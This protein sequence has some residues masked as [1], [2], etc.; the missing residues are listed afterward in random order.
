ML[1][2]VKFVY[3]DTFNFTFKA[4]LSTRPEKYMGELEQWN[5]A[6][7]YLEEALKK[8]GIDYTINPGDGAFYGPK[9]DFDVKDALG[10]SWQLATIQV[11]FQMPSRFGL[12]YEGP[13]GARH[14]PVMLHRAILG[15]IERFMGVLI[16]HYAGKFPVWLSPVQV[17]LLPVSDQYNSFCILLAEKMR[18]AGIRAEANCKQETINAKIRDAQL[19]HIPYMLVVGKKELESGKL[20]VRT[21]DG[22]IE[23]DVPIDSFISRVLSEIQSR[24]A[25]QSQ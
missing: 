3:V 10:R 15:S 14:T 19:E 16:E 25:W 6:E 13:D 9:I 20:A 18:A 22:K 11:D 17:A 24:K 7:R 21:R 8:N 4:K 2:F 1:D 5:E 12:E 23:H